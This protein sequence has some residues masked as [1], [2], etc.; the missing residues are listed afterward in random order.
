[1]EALRYSPLRVIAGYVERNDMRAL[2]IARTTRIA[3]ARNRR[4]QQPYLDYRRQNV[5][6]HL[7]ELDRERRDAGQPGGEA[8]MHDGW[9]RDESCSLPHLRELLVEMGTVIEERGLQPWE[10]YGK[11]F[12][13]DILP[14]RSWERYASILDFASSPEVLAPIARHAGYVPHLSGSQPPGVRLMESS[15]KFDPQPDG[16]WRASQLWHLDYHAYP[17][18]YVT[19]ALRDIGPEDGPLHFLGQ[20]TSRRV[21]G[22]LG[23]RSRRAP[24]RVT[25]EVM[26]E[27]IEAQEVMRF[28]ASAGTVLFIDSSSCFHLGSRGPR[29]P[30]YHMQYSYVSPVRNDFSDVLRPQVDF[31]I[32]GGASLS[33]RLA[34]DR[35]LL[36][37]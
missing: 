9:M 18:I 11:P 20:A 36:G 22:A 5:E 10:E 3:R 1:V 29:R 16:P 6:R 32:D 8:R 37:R 31:P 26:D 25:D 13:K 7:A 23:Y 34:L 14:E 24:Y 12:I 2:G 21:A 35:E 17:L 19:V 28:T 33:R 27:H 30:R 15:T 4:R